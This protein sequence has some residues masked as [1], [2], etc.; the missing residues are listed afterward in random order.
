MPSLSLL[1]FD[2]FVFFAAAA[3][4]TERDREAALITFLVTATGVTLLGA[5]SAFWGLVAGGLALV[6]LPKHAN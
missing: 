3:M 2:F 4:A 1:F 6:I 5:G